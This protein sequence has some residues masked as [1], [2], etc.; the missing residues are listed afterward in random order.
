MERRTRRTFDMARH[1]KVR[2]GRG[3][4]AVHDRAAVFFGTSNERAATSRPARIF[5]SGHPARNGLRGLPATSARTA[6]WKA[7][8]AAYP[9]EAARSGASSERSRRR[10]ASLVKGALHEARKLTGLRVPCFRGFRV[11]FF[12]AVSVRFR[13][14]GVGRVPGRFPPKPRLRVRALAREFL[15]TATPSSVRDRA[16]GKFESRG[17]RFRFF[18]DGR[19]SPPRGQ[20]FPD[21]GARTGRARPRLC[22][23]PGRGTKARVIDEIPRVKG[24]YPLRKRPS[25]G[26]TGPA[27]GKSPAGRKRRFGT[28]RWRLAGFSSFFAKI[29]SGHSQKHPSRSFGQKPA[30]GNPATRFGPL[31]GCLAAAAL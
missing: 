6:P 25:P 29:A 26:R 21:A 1:G 15:K 9:R 28:F 4:W 13:F 16:K 18:G 14:R 10:G 11:P 30:A 5:P 19:V 3:H 12:R 8:A 17:E 24:D 23:G 27:P 20:D 7:C 22:P 2:R 31:S